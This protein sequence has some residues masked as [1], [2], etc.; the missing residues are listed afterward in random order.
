MINIQKYKCTIL[1]S[2]LTLSYIHMHLQQMM[3]E[4]SN[5]PTISHNISFAILKLHILWERILI[6]S[7]IIS[8]ASAIF[9]AATY[10]QFLY[11]FFFLLSDPLVWASEHVQQ[12]IA[13]QCRQFNVALPN[14]DYFQM[15]GE[16]LCCLTEEQFKMYASEAGSI[17]SSRLDIW[18]SGES[19]MHCC[20]IWAV[21]WEYQHQWPLRN[22]SI[23]ISLRCPRRLIR[24]DT[25]RR[26]GIEVKSNDSWNRQSTGGDNCR[27]GLACAECLAWSESLLYTQNP[28]CWFSRETAHMQILFQHICIANVV[29]FHVNAFNIVIG[30]RVS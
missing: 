13:W 18:R 17:L 26:R 5:S 1:C 7:K 6:F 14:M 2:S 15:T 30:Y 11:Y 4:L 21:P 3:F 23:Q 29:W 8:K 9:K 25:F 20:I 10:I 28:Q 22:V 24:V 27:F 12:W 16:E 19:A